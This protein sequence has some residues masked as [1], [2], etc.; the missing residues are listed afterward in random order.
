[1]PGGPG[2]A[3]GAASVT[4]RREPSGLNLADMTGLATGI[5]ARTRR[6]DASTSR[7]PPSVAAAKVLLSADQARSNQGKADDRLSRRLP[8]RSHTMVVASWATVTAVLP[9][10]VTAGAW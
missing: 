1:M 4:A 9:S 10:G 5:V 7:N 8:V 2:G 6:V 3:Q